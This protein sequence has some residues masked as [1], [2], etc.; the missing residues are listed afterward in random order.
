MT[1]QGNII[2]CVLARAQRHMNNFVLSREK[3]WYTQWRQQLNIA[4][5]IIGIYFRAVYMDSYICND[6]YS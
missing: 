4:V 5:E 6:L 2:E 1:K 3:R